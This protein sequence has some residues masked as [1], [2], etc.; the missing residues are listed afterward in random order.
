MDA[1][2][3]TLT[4]QDQNAFWSL[5]EWTNV[6][7]RDAKIFKTSYVG[8]FME[9]GP[10]NTIRFYDFKIETDNLPGPQDRYNLPITGQIFFGEQSKIPAEYGDELLTGHRR[11]AFGRDAAGNY[12]LGVST[13][14]KSSTKP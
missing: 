8:C 12:R 6:P 10:G 5:F 11:L 9:P 1:V 2:Q 7:P 14:K 13:L 4:A 3:V